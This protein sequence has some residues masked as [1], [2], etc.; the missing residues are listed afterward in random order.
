MLLIVNS[1]DI[2]LIGTVL[3]NEFCTQ[4]IFVVGHDGDFSHPVIVDCLADNEGFESWH[5]M[6]RLDVALSVDTTIE[7]ER[8]NSVA[9][10]IDLF[11]QSA[12]KVLVEFMTTHP[13][14]IPSY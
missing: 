11:E 4:A 3:K 9:E 8:G 1:G 12:R 13:E 5:I 10:C 7:S 2:K 14:L 6:F